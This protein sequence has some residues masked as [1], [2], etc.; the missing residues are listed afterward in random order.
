MC[1]VTIVSVITLELFR[2]HKKEKI[3]SYGN[4]IARFAF[5]VLY[6][7]I[8]YSIYEIFISSSDK[9]VYLIEHS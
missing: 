5:P 8:W 9:I 4:M 2:H 1:G 7:L 6:V 3:W